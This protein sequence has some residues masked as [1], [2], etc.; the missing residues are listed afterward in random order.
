MTKTHAQA[1]GSYRV[2]AWLGSHYEDGGEPDEVTPILADDPHLWRDDPWFDSGRAAFDIHPD[3]LPAT[4]YIYTN[5]SVRSPPVGNP[6]DTSEWDGPVEDGLLFDE[7][8]DGD[9]PFGCEVWGRVLFV[10]EEGLTR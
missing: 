8:Y 4:L 9:R 1:E 6:V 5:D 7:E 2:R 3:D 10:V